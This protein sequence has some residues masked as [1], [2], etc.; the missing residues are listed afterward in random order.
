MNSAG[1]PVGVGTRFLYD[2]EVAEITE[3]HP[4][5]A[6]LHAILRSSRTR[7]VLRLS[8]NELLTGERALILPDR[9]GP[10][11]DD[12]FDTPGVVLAN[13][14]RTERQTVLERAAHVREVL[15]GYQ[16]GHAE[17]AADSEPR[18]QY[19]PDVPLM[20][21]YEAKAAELGVGVRTVRRWIGEFQRNGEAGLVESKQA[22]ASTGRVDERWVQT[23]VE[24]MVEHQDQSKPSRLLVID[25]T[26]ARVIR[27][28]GPDAVELPSRATA[29]R[30]L[31]ELEKQHPTFRLSTKRN[32]DIADRPAGVYGKL[33]PTRP[34]EYVLMDTTRLDVF[35]LDPLTLRWMQAELTVA[36]DWYTRCITGLRVT[37]VSTKSVDAAAVLYQTYRPPPAAE[38][39]P[40]HAV[41]PEHGIPRTVL[42]DVGAIEQPTVGRAGPVIVPETVVIDHG[43]IYLSEHVTSTCE[44]LGV[45][46]QPARLRTG[47]DK[48]P[49][50][51]FFRTIREDL[52]QTLPGYKGPDVHSRGLDVESEAFFYLDELEAIIREWVAVVYHHRPH[53]GLVE[54]GV[55]GLELSPAMMF[56]HGVARAGYIEAP[57]DPDLAYEFL[58]IAWRTIQPYGVDFDRRRYNGPGLNLYREMTS[59]YGGKAKGR[60]PIHYNPDDITCIYFRDPDSRQWHTLT[61]EH[62]PAMKMP[63][64]EDALKFARTQAASKYRYPDDRLAVADLLERWNLGLGTTLPER[65]IALRLAREAAQL[66]AGVAGE[67]PVSSLPSVAKVL[68]AAKYPEPQAD[69]DDD[70]EASMEI[71][72]AGDD[73]DAD[74]DPDNAGDWGT[75]YADALEDV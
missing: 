73:D 70:V 33:R 65:R 54:P 35:A 64:S 37:P 72:E 21:R 60:W 53:D 23:A 6:G 74:F 25:R 44:R 43:K 55:P 24:I 36:M 30:V 18:A 48:G 52:L 57:R 10:S 4:S 67:P 22:V 69:Q 68:A 26:H 29:F 11:S 27:R 12:A 39:W 45:S 59:P 46:I 1:V 7:Q 38:S 42:V 51:R 3:M 58:N 56:E 63:M 9:G 75:F 19:R 28:F 13:M 2:G 5:P 47:R 20:R 62:A 49:V 41:W 17:L 8:V 34:G 50:E 61:W 71:P 31:S 14:D 15:T 16:S 32:R 40:T 66:G